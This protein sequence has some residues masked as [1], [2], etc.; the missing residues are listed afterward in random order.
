MRVGLRGKICNPEFCQ[1]FPLSCFF[2]A[3]KFARSLGLLSCDLIIRIFGHSYP[4]CRARPGLL[5]LD[6]CELV[7]GKGALCTETLK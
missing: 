2:L 7:D 1:N 5:I 6:S 4:P 3:M